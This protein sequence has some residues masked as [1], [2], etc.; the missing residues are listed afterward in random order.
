MS[1]DFG[2]T[3]HMCVICAGQIGK[4]LW[5]LLLKLSQENI[6]FDQEG[7]GRKYIYRTGLERL[8]VAITIAVRWYIMFKQ[9][10][11]LCGRATAPD[12]V[13]GGRRWGMSWNISIIGGP[14]KA[15]NNLK[16]CM[17]W[18]ESFKLM[19]SNIR[20]EL[21][22][23]GLPPKWG[24]LRTSLWKAIRIMISIA[25]NDPY[26][27]GKRLSQFGIFIWS[28][29]SWLLWPCISVLNVKS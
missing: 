11:C 10:I 28:I 25:I 18:G 26:A 21:S 2:E 4:G 19:I 9:E 14:N 8:V 3:L 24:N 27:H 23:Y 7:F 16:E 1:S 13:L 29:L 17:N 6:W 15:P 20:W 5:E 22:G 12:W